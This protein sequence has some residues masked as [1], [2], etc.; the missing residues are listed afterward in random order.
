MS[1]LCRNT[2]TRDAPRL[3]L[4]MSEPLAMSRDLSAWTYDNTYNE[5]AVHG[6]VRVGVHAP[7]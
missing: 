7:R 1:R 5:Y 2:M 6:A 3:M 4:E